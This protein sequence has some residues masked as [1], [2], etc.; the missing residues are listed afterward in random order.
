MRTDEAWRHECEVRWLAGMPGWRI[1]E[2]LKAAEE[3]RG[4]PAA[5]KLLSD[6][7]EARKAARESTG[8]GVSTTKG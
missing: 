4:R 5:E 8:T 3:K 6:V 7:R 1:A 2:Y